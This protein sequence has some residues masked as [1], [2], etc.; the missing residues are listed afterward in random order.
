[1]GHFLQRIKGME[2]QTQEVM[3]SI[4][5]SSLYTN[6]PHTEGIY[7]VKMPRTK[8]AGILRDTTN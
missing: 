2:V 4:N 7:A 6:I 5:V 3:C 8:P 1:M